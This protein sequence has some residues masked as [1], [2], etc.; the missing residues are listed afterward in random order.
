MDYKQLIK[1]IDKDTVE[2]DARTNIDDI[3]DQFELDLPEDEDY[4]TLGGFVFSHLGY[5][6]KTG[7]SFQYETLKI[8]ITN[9]E[10]R[11][12]KRIKIQKKRQE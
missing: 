2:I 7:D 4:D 11:R 9:A 6:P 8:T 12:I 3:N 10:R 5:I 1:Q